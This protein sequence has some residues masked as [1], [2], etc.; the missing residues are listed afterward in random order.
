[1]NILKIIMFSSERVQRIIDA[2]KLDF[3][4]LYAS[5]EP[6][7]TYLYLR[8]RV[9]ACRNRM[10]KNKRN[11]YLY[12][13]QKFELFSKSMLTRFHFDSV[14]RGL[15]VLISLR[16]ISVRVFSI[17]YALHRFEQGY[18]QAS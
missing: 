15:V 10:L 17:S 7:S 18:D 13:R 12:D 11:F 9:K 14:Y 3:F 4:H 1:M 2:F 8:K 16:E 5:M 6:I